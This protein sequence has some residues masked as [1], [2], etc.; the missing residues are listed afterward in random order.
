[1]AGLRRTG[2]DLESQGRED[3]NPSS[4]K[5]NKSPTS[6]LIHVP[7]PKRLPMHCLQLARKIPASASTWSWR[8][9]PSA[10]LSPG[11]PSHPDLTPAPARAEARPISP[12]ERTAVGGGET[13]RARTQGRRLD[14]GGA[15]PRAR[16]CT[17]H[18]QTRNKRKSPLRFPPRPPD[19]TSPLT[20]PFGARARA[21]R[22]REIESLPVPRG[23]SSSS[24]SAAAARAAASSSRR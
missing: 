11:R 8:A 21:R 3:S 15:G 9:T 6:K 5:S 20:A 2:Q 13:E 19:L 18:R 24:A 1:M 10:K 4:I 16:Q 22:G 14:R 12:G 17:P 23:S 7:L